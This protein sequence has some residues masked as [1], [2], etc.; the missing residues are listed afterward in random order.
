[1][2][3]LRL[4]LVAGLFLS[5]SYP[6]SLWLLFGLAIVVR[7]M[8]LRFRPVSEP[9]APAGSAVIGPDHAATNGTAGRAILTA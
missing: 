5:F 6:R 4:R 7:Q 8:A 3:T 1:M 2:K 9:A